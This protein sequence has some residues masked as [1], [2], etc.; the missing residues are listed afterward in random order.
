MGCAVEYDFAFE[1]QTLTPNADVTVPVQVFLT[2]FPA[3]GYGQIDCIV[4]EATGQ[5]VRLDDLGAAD[6]AGI[7]R[8]VKQLIEERLCRN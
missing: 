3:A 7:G 2:L 5:A 1:A 6:Q 4:I 8:T